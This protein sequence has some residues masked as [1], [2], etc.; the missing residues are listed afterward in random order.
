MK[1]IKNILAFLLLVSIS[2]MQA[3]SSSIDGCSLHDQVNERLKRPLNELFLNAC[4]V[5]DMIIFA[6]IK[7]IADVNYCDGYGRT[8]LKICI[9]NFCFGHKK[10]VGDPTMINSLIKHHNIL[11]VRDD[12]GNTIFM[13]FLAC[14]N[15]PA[16]KISA[17]T[18]ESM[19]EKFIYAGAGVNCINDF[20]KSVYEYACEC[21]SKMPN[22]KLIIEQAIDRSKGY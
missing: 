8:P 12:Y 6:A 1:N 13:H 7:N 19:L 2:L 18:A 15:A 14:L 21:S 16:L 9:D 10:V 5:G 17:D 20:E 3:A 22:I 4:M 11:N